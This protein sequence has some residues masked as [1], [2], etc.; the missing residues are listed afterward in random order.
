MPR[1]DLTQ[2]PLLG[3]IQRP[4][5]PR[6]LR[7][8]LVGVAEVD[9]SRPR[10]LAQW[11][12]RVETQVMN[13]CVAHAVTS[14]AE[15]LA[16]RAGVAPPELDRRWV[17]ARA[18]QRA[19][20]FPQD[21]GCYLAD[22]LDASLAGIPR[23]DAEPRVYGFEPTYSPGPEV[24]A[25]ALAQDYL[26]SHQPFYGSDPGGL[27]AGVVT[28]LDAG[29]PVVIALNWHRAFSDPMDGV[30]PTRAPTDAGFLG[31][32]AVYAWGYQPMGAF[33]L[34]WCRNSWGES[35]PMQPGTRLNPE[36]GPG[37]FAIPGPLFANGVVWECR[38]VAPN[39]T[40]VPTPQPQPEPEPDADAGRAV[41]AEAIAIALTT[42]A[43]LDDA[44]ASAPA[45]AQAEAA[46]K[47]DGAGDVWRALRQRWPDAG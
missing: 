44:A 16:N 20:L 47:R 30:L 39:P 22:G 36:A 17:Y 11:R 3:A 13:D 25:D 34:V 2:P 42:W 45:R 35:F 46:A 7:Y 31:G 26:E 12:P 41:A 24:D 4:P 23:E 18:R 33:G 8:R 14:A 40:M 21:G 28:A 27:L 32:H 37:D 5:D 10:S 15:L 1:D 29:M 43:T 38:A 9:L 19:G 6:E